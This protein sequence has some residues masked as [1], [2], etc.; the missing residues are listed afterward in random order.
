MISKGPH[1][2]ESVE[3]LA[4]I[5]GTGRGA[6]EDALLLA[7]RILQT[8]G[9]LEELARASIKELVKIAGIGPV[10]AARIRAAFELC[11]RSGVA[12]AP[13]TSEPAPG[14]LDLLM[15]R[16]SG[17]VPVGER[18]LLAC[19]GEQDPLTLALGEVLGEESRIGSFLVRLIS[20]GDGPWSLISLRPGGPPEP[21]EHVATERFLNA[22]AL[23]GVPIERVLLMN[24]R[25]H[26]ILGTEAGE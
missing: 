2:L 4:L 22:A 8:L 12:E 3:L 16:L 10:K 23:L 1:A 9:S 19:Q 15:E 14:P 26:W 11:L 25:E 18:V 6:N 13:E 24:G 17:Q 5:L 20:A 21:S 7:H